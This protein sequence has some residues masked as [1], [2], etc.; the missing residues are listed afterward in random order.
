M[1]YKITY[2]DSFMNRNINNMFLNSGATISYNN[3]ILMFDDKT[4]EKV[5]KQYTEQGKDINDSRF[6]VG[7]YIWVNGKTNA[8]FE[9]K[10]L[11][12]DAIDQE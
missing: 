2:D 5:I 1:I 9:N 4:C 12:N 11:K 7:Y 8:E 10:Y 6:L 3:G